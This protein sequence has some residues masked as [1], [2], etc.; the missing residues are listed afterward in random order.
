MLNYYYDPI[1][2]LQYDYLGE[3]FIIDLECIPQDFKFDTEQWIKYMKQDRVKIFDFSP[4]S[5]CE[6]IGKITNYRL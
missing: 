2:G 6:I 3:L 1:L 4:Q 5:Y